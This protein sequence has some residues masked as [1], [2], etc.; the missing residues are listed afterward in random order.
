LLYNSKEWTIQPGQTQVWLR[1]EDRSG[2]MIVR[3][4]FE[5]HLGDH[6]YA[7][8]MLPSPPRCLTEQIAA[9]GQRVDC[10]IERL[11]DRDTLVRELNLDKR[12]ETFG[13]SG[14]VSPLGEAAQLASFRVLPPAVRAQ[15]WRVLADLP[16][17]TYAGRVI[18]RIG[19]TGEAFSIDFDGG[20]GPSVDTIIAEPATGDI[21]GF[22]RTL[23]RI[24]DPEFLSKELPLKIRTPAVVDYW[25]YAVAER[26]ESLT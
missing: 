14:R 3:D 25:V 10:P 12:F 18:D 9:G 13:L 24:T 1:T 2:R 19:R 7:P 8:G 17:I 16:G 20:H 5:E 26:R 4:A 15:L 21:L 6:L 11:A 22:E 23:K